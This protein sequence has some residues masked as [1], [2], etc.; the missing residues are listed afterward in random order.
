MCVEGEYLRNKRCW[1]GEEYLLQY[2]SKVNV[3]HHLLSLFICVHLKAAGLMILTIKHHKLV[4]E[5]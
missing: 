1:T 5:E 4:K 3:T 2:N